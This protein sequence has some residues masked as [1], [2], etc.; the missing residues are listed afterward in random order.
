MHL[1]LQ[2]VAPKVA[3]Q[4]TPTGLDVV[5][6]RVVKEGLGVSRDDTG[7]L[8]GIGLDNEVTT[9]G[10]VL[11]A[12]SQLPECVDIAE[13]GCSGIDDNSD[14]KVLVVL[15]ATALVELDHYHRV[16]RHCVQSHCRFRQ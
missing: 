1:W 13:V 10:D 14:V 16:E 6:M 4:W 5:A 15:G 3:Q 11:E 9:L 12:V 2:H 8:L 7:E